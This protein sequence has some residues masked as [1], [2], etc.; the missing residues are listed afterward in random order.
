MIKEFK[1]NLLMNTPPILP[2]N[3]LVG[4]DLFRISLA[5]LIYAFHSYIHLRCHYGVFDKFVWEGAVAMTA[6]FLLS[7]FSLQISSAKMNFT[8]VQHLK[9]FYIKRLI[10]IIPLFSGSSPNCVGKFM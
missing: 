7:G 3:R 1:H 6:F 4:L 8:D 5:I 10:S 9:T 2:S